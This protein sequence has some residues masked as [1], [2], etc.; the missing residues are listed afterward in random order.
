MND[1]LL[2]KKVL[3]AFEQSATT[4]QYGKVYRFNDGP[5][6]IKQITLSFGTT[7]YG[8]LSTIVRR[9]VTKGGRV[10][11]RLKPYVEKIGK[12]A[13]ADD[14]QFIKLLQEAGT[15]VSM[16]LI[17]DA[18]DEMYIQ[19]AMRWCEKSKLILPLSR[20]VVADSFLQSGSILSS[21][22]NKFS[23]KIPSVGGD[24]RKWIESYCIVRKDWLANHSRKILNKTV[25]RMNFM[26]DRIEAGDWNLAQPEYRANGVK[27]VNA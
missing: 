2:I 11:D 8:N 22:R 24:E 14:E 18:Y 23:A 4:I 25:Y 21:L 26:L 3:L 13:L 5:G 17:Q 12:V 19:P 15:D 7:E 9:Y 1:T 20:L 27:I 10:A 16:Q 6:N